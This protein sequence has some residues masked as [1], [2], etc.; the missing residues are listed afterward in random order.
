[1]EKLKN[2]LDTFYNVWYI[3]SIKRVREY[4]SI[5]EFSTRVHK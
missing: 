3:K 2:F 4:E 5:W 1:M